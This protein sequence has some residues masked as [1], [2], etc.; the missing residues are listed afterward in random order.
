MTKIQERANIF[1]EFLELNQLYIDYNGIHYTL[2]NKKQEI[3]CISERSEE[4]YFFIQGFNLANE[5]T[6]QYIK[7]VDELTAQNNKTVENYE[8]ILKEKDGE[9]LLDV[10]KKKD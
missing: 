6:K 1:K 7:M 2:V 5:N 4:M 10:K 9:S 8:K 3:L